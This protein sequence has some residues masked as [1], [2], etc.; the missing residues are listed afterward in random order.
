MS[1]LKY[2]HIFEPIQ[3]A[4]AL[5]RNRLFSSPQGYY[6]IGP[7]LFPNGDM[8]GFFETKAR[9]GYASVC[10]GD[11]IVDWK[12]GRH[13]DWLIPADNPKMLP[14]L[15]K[16][17]SAITRHGAVASAELSHAGM[18]AKASFEAGAPLL[19]PVDMTD[20]YGQV[21]AM[22]EAD[23]EHVIDA[24]GKAAAFAKQCGF[25]MVTIHGGHGWLIRSSG[26]NGSIREGTS[27]AA[28]SRTACGSRW[29]SWKASGRLS[30]KT[31]LS[32]S[33]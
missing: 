25:G 16:L 19:G 30:V 24:F 21:R 26:Q 32:S 28:A 9:G 31:F 17:A 23:I 33:A 29:P 3:A 22:T 18:Y 20:K 6:N 2:P 4:G 5:F 14:G 12:N 15:S 8:I 27:G 11:L 7:D 10:I 1:Q 13:Y